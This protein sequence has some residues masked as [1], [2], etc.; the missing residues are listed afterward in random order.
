MEYSVS[1]TRACRIMCFHKSLYYYRSRRDDSEVEAGIR[2]AAEYGDGF[3]K[4]YNRLRREGKPWNHKKVYRV[5]QKM[6]MNKKSRLRKRLP[7]RVKQPLLT[8]DV[9]GDTWSLDFVSD[10]LESGR[11]FRVLNILDDC[12][13]QSVAMEISMSMPAQR[14]IKALE[15]TIWINGK[16][17]RIR[18]DN[19]PEFI[20]KELEA[21]CTANDVEHVF[22]Q[23]G[24]PTQNSYVERFNGSYRRGV[25]D[26]YLFRTLQDVRDITEKWQLD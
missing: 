8:P 18:T 4:I 23:P 16:P 12:T 17:K 13:R 14:V 25:L 9:P 22:T 19:G 11:K 1:I 7:A 3:W 20:S 24:C 5:Y 26:A 2:A 21:W 10:K 15:K 6:R